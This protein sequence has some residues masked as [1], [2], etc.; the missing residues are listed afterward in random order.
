MRAHENRDRIRIRVWAAVALPI[1]LL[2][3]FLIERSPVSR[4]PAGPAQIDREDTRAELEALRRELASV[5][6]DVTRMQ[7]ESPQPFE[8]AGAD[9]APAPPD[10]GELDLEE[11]GLSELPDIAQI[12]AKLELQ[13]LGFEDRLLE[14]GDDWAGAQ[15]LEAELTRSLGEGSVRAT[16]SARCGQTLCSVNFAFE[17]AIE[18]DEQFHEIPNIMPWAGE[19]FA[20]IDA[21]DPRRAIIYVAREGESLPELP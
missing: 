10:R 20:M 18:L 1:A 7:A 4:A 8:R 12:E 13:Q 3:G 9:P 5:R 17:D 6:A 11:S 15:S 21:E 16:A 14:E 2:A 19:G